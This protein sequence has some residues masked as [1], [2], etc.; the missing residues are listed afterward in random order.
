MLSDNFYWFYSQ[1]I[2]LSEL[3]SL[4]HPELAK[5]VSVRKEGNEY[6]YDITLENPSSYLSFFNRLALQNDNG[7]DV[8][9]VFWSDNFVTLL[10]HEK[11]TLQAR[12]AVSDGGL[13]LP[14]MVIAE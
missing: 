4:P 10:P 12:I 14:R 9:P 1:H 7:E 6:V 13:H 11:K 5:T 8:N 2:S 3:Q